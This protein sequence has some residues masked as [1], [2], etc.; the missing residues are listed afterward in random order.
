MPDTVHCPFCRCSCPSGASRCPECGAG[1]PDSAEHTRA[2]HRAAEDP[3]LIELLKQGKRSEAV[4]RYREMTDLDLIE[5]RK[6]VDHLIAG[7][8]AGAGTQDPD[9][10]RNVL[11]L[12]N[13]QQLFQ[14]I[15]LYRT[16]TGRGLAE[17]KEAVETLA[18]RNQVAIPTTIG[19]SGFVVAIVA[20]LIVLAAVL[21][22]RMR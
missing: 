14:A 1:L 7:S 16:Q 10:E 4:A 15:R 5:A 8:A 21:V 11:K 3:Q 19:C 20:A 13:Q 6:A 17:S 18:R 22:A 2:A 9:L 12:L